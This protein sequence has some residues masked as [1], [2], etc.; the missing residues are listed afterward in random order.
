[1]SKTSMFLLAAAALAMMPP[2]PAGARSL[3]AQRRFDLAAQPLDQAL[4]TIAT[5][6]G[7]NL[8]APADLLAGRTAPALHATQTPIQ[9]VQGL[10]A[11]SG[12]E[13]VSVGGDFVIR[14]DQ[15][16]AADRNKAASED[17]A[18]V[19]TGSLVRGAPPTSPVITIG[20]DAIDRSGATSVERLLRDLPQNSQAGVGQE[21]FNASGAGTD[22]TE[23]GAG[24][25]LRGLGQRATLVLL[26]GRR[27]APSGVGSFVDVSMI[28]V[29]ALQRVEILTDGASAIYGSD[30]VG[31]VVNFILKDRFDGLET[32]FQAGTTTAGGGSSLLGSLTGGTHWSSGRV[33]LSYEYR[34]DFPIKAGERDYTSGLQ[35][36]VSVTPDEVRHSLLGIVHQSLA[37][38]LTLELTGTYARRDTD[39]FFFQSSIPTTAHAAARSTGASADLTYAFGGSW[40]LDLAG[41]LFVSRN[42]ERAIS[43]GI[44]LFNHIDTTNRL[45]E[46]SLKLDGTLLNLPGGPVKTAIGAQL[47]RESYVDV[48]E[49]SVS[50]AV[51]RRNV[52]W[53]RSLFGEVDVPLVSRTNRVPGVERLLL[54]GAI[55][56]EKYDGFKSTLDPKLGLL[57]SPVDGLAFRSSYATSFRAPLQSETSGF[58][59]AY[60]FPVSLVYTNPAGA[61]SGGAALVLTGSNPK[62]Q[63]ERSKSWTLGTQWT[64]PSLPGLT[65]SLN[66]YRV[67][68]SNRIVLPTNQIVIVG[69]PALESLVTRNPSA[70]IVTGIVNGASQI[71]DFSGPG[72]TNGGAGPGDVRTIVDVRYN[73]SARTRT[74]GLDL[75]LHYDFKLAGYDLGAEINANHVLRFDSRLTATTPIQSLLDTPYQP[76]DWRFNAGMQWRRA[77][78]SGSVT[79]HHADGYRDD[80]RLVVVPVASFTTVDAGITYAPHSGPLAGTSMSL[81]ADNLFDQAPPHLANDPGSTRGLGYDPVNASGRGR[82]VSLQLR[83]S[84]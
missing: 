47:R 65:A 41:Q 56:Y 59:I 58:Y 17:Q 50:S 72:F 49:T 4:R 27:L 42:R 19:V 44:G 38:G 73:N 70:D 16:R 25:N 12:L 63:P 62:I 40:R 22:I 14:R 9:A 1:M 53:V 82:F 3:P 74:S 10:L 6:S 33:L 64:P 48:F 21:N 69:N 36:D 35:P 68:F 52:R 7:I 15:A 20:R 78:W 18:I 31:G 66:Y 83:Q 13:V 11:G 39:R 77:A 57:W 67:D 2:V 5:Q 79:V 51:S 23:H 37:P 24:L 76:L 80:R 75:L 43:E 55:R 45:F 34:K 8:I 84:W 28:P 32:T 46:S 71:L 29:S 81:F 26:D 60:Y 61:P 30:A 54:T